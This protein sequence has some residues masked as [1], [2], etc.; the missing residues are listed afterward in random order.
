MLADLRR[1]APAVELEDLLL[2]LRTG[3]H[4]PADAIARVRDYKS[5]LLGVVQEPT[6]MRVAIADDDEGRSLAAVFTH[7]DNFNA[8]AAEQHGD[9]VQALEMDGRSL[10]GQLSN[11]KTMHGLVFNCSGLARPVAFSADFCALVLKA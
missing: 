10:F 9:E 3:N 8:W 1:A 2:R 6:G 7:T 5:Y 4:P 11:F